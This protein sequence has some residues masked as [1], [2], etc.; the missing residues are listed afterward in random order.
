MT[1]KLSMALDKCKI[2]DRDAVHILITTGEAFGIDIS[3]LIIN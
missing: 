2:S 1:P 3:K